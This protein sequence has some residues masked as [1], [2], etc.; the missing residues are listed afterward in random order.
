MAFARAEKTKSGEP[1]WAVYWRDLEG[2]QRKQR[3]SDPKEADRFLKLK[4]A[5]HLRGI[6]EPSRD[7]FSALWDRWD[8]EASGGLTAKVKKTYVDAGK[9]LLLPYFG[10]MALSDINRQLIPRWI[11]WAQDQAEAG[12]IEKAFTVLSSVMGYALDLGLVAANPCSH[13]GK[14]LP[15]VQN[16]RV[17][18]HLTPPQVLELSVAVDPSFRAMILSMGVLGLRPGEAIALRLGDLDLNAGVLHVRRSAVD[19]GREMVDRSTTKTGRS[20]TV[21]LMGTQ[22]AFED[23]LRSKYNLD[24]YGGLAGPTLPMDP[25]DLLFESRFTSGGFIKTAALAALV[26]RA[27]KRIGVEGLSADDLRHVAAANLIEAYPDPSFAQWVLGHSSPVMTLSRYDQGTPARWD[28]AIEAVSA[29]YG[30]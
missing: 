14:Y 12:S 25:G 3:F 22:K 29:S 24:N 7:K 30:R 17:R 5:D 16:K 18:P 15:N 19:V 2:K 28:R 9:R 11:T 27:G 4:Q 26:R 23:H 20:R 21:P 13:M 1:R 10:K 8:R 6:P